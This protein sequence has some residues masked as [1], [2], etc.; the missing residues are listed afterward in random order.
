MSKAFAGSFLFYR[1]AKPKP[2][3]KN[4]LVREYDPSWVVAVNI[5]GSP[6]DRRMRPEFP[7]CDSCLAHV[8]NPAEG[9]DDNPAK[10]RPFCECVKLVNRLMRE[11]MLVR[12]QL[13]Q[14]GRI[15]ELQAMVA[16]KKLGSLQ[17]VVKVYLERGPKDRKQRVNSLKAMFEQSSG[18]E[19]EE[20]GWKDLTRDLVYSWAEMRQEAGRRG[21][22]GLKDVQAMPVDG[23]P[24]LR[25]LKAEGKLPALDRKTAMAAM[26]ANTTVLGYL[27]NVKTIFG[28]DSRQHVLRGMNLPDLEHF[29]ETKLTLKKPKG[30]KKIEAGRWAEMIEAEDELKLSNLRVWVLH[31]LLLRLSCRPK[32]A[33]YARPSWLE[34]V[35]AT[36]G[37]RTRIVI[38]NRPEEGFILKAGDGA[39]ERAI[40]LPDILVK[41]IREV[42]TETS[43]IGAKHQTEA[44][45]LLAEH[46][47]WIKQFLPKGS[48]QTS[49]LLRH[50]GAAERMTSGDSTQAAALLGHK[51]T[52]MVE[53]TYGAV[54]ETLDPISDDEILRRVA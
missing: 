24:Q 4:P 5:P 38:V 9:I 16:P 13:L 22:L 15:E 31:Q 1:Q 44:K 32:E 29:L 23:W 41:A 48:T 33:R 40:W 53:T 17:E 6:R 30:H 36:V 46:S 51:T 11:E 8:A 37:E 49:Y 12:T 34:T 27:T 7:I 2:R 28:Q 45:G 21:W 52:Q 20:M 39:T 25:A 42:S 14:Q 50:S 43:L 19:F 18:R 35:K 54:L 47:T 26:A 10:A 3:W